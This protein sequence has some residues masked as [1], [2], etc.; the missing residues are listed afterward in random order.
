[1]RTRNHG[2]LLAVLLALTLGAC[3]GAEDA[4]PAAD[5]T[6]TTTTTAVTGATAEVIAADEECLPDE[7]CVTVTAEETTGKEL[8]LMLYEAVD[9]EWPQK[10]RTLPT[11]SWVVSE[12]P[13]VPDS[14]PL[15]V[16]LNFTDNL[17]AISS[18]P[19]EGSRMGL[20][21]ASGVDSIMVVESTDARGFSDLTLMYEPGTAMNFGTVALALP[22]GDTCELNPYHPDCLTGPMF[23]EVSMLGEEG[24]V[25]GAVYLDVADVDGDGIDDI[26]T[27]GE[28]HFEEPDLPLEVLKLGVYYLNRDLTV[29]ETE[30]IDAWTEEDQTLYSPWGVKVID[31][32][33]ETMIIVG[34]NI[35]GL[36]PLEDGYGDVLSY[37]KE[38]GTWERSHIMR[39]TDPT[40]SNYNAMIVVVCDIDQDGDTDL[41]LS[42]AFGTSAVGSWMENTGDAA[43]PWTAHLQEMAA[44]TDPAIRGTLGYKCT[45]LTNDG[46][47]EVIYNA[48]FDIPDTNPPRYR[49]EIWLAVNPG[50]DGWDAPW[51]MVAIDDDNWASADMWFHDFDGDGYLDLIANQIFSSTVTRYTHP[52]A[53]AT[54]AWTPEIIIS[55]LT[56]PSDMW[57]TDMDGDGLVDVVSADHT[58]HAGVWHKNPGPGSDALWE[59]SSIYR[60]VRMPGDFEMADLDQDGDLDWVGVSMTNGQAFVVEQIEPPAGAVV[61]ISLPDD[62]DQEITKL[63]VMLASEVPVTGMPNALLALVDNT[64]ADGDGEMDV[65]QIL[66]PGR[67]LVLSVEDVG[68][69]G[70]YH[71][72][73]GVYVE[74]GGNFQPVS[75][76]DY[77]SYSE[78]LTFGNGTVTAEIDM[79]LYEE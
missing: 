37:R 7:L 10:F 23:W 39:N 2:L 40:T 35:P 73:A 58:A 64:D 17:F 38:N 46:Y 8:R 13:A 5:P 54:A 12:Y 18:E 77:L 26:V 28:P 60:N 76:V 31:H 36:A 70:D 74:G 34:T 25:P 52:G 30:I 22:A 71:I 4:G 75:G 63:V 53:D 24:F 44:D 67:D 66:A 1:M 19:L 15:R 14:F 51:E 33:G 79:A 45:D 78:M 29:R 20:A 21:I 16:R 57:L 55:G 50:P 48:M 72:V 41:A 49:G 27:V 61:T 65:D 68:L 62:F 69:A 6:T 3:S 47:P 59:M 9:D 56:S 32:A 11:P 42:S 43:D